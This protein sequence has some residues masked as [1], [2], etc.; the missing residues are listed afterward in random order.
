MAITV[1]IS[2][3]GEDGRVLN[4]SRS[5]SFSDSNPH[6]QHT[7]SG[8]CFSFPE[9]RS[10]QFSPLRIGEWSLYCSV[11]PDF[12]TRIKERSDSM[13]SRRTWSVTG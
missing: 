13:L 5:S 12:N 7:L 3:S 9:L 4:N 6:H 10:I 1:V 11:I 8:I 2:I